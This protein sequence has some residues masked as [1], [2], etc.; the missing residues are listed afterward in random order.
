VEKAGGGEGGVSLC[1][2]EDLLRISDARVR[3]VVLEVNHRLWL[4]SGAG[5][6][7]PEGHVVSA[8]RRNG[9]VGP[10]SDLV[11]AEESGFGGSAQSCCAHLFFGGPIHHHHAGQRIVHVVVVVLA[12]L[13][14]GVDGDWD[15]SHPDGAEEGG[16]PAGAV[17]GDDENALLAADAKVDEGASCATG[18]L[19]K[20]SVSD[21]G[22]RG[23]DGDLAGASFQ[24]ALEEVG[25]HVVALRQLKP[26]HLNGQC[27]FVGWRM[28][29]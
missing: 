18:Q 1:N 26:S 22:G 6:V 14:E 19:A 15:G 9:Y 29:G 16:H 27:S 12:A 11:C 10:C 7:Q 13:E 8:R 3:D 4:A 5:A 24:V 20:I 17:V 2:A 25:A 23:V 28:A 21:V